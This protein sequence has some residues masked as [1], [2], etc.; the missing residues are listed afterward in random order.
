MNRI[1][2]YGLANAREAY[3]PVRYAYVDYTEETKIVESIIRA[4]SQMKIK[5]PSVDRIYIIDDKWYLYGEY[6]KAIKQNSIEQ[7]VIFKDMLETEGAEL[8][9]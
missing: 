6:Q 1:W 2:L 5:N 9:F 4:A 3:R 8:R 7:N